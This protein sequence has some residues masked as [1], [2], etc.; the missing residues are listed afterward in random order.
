MIFSRYNK[1]ILTRDEK[2]WLEYESFEY[3][4]R[5]GPVTRQDGL[6]SKKGETRRDE[7]VSISSRLETSSRETV[8]KENFGLAKEKFIKSYFFCKKNI[9]EISHILFGRFLGLK[10]FA[11]H[12]KFNIF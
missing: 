6:V 10:I 4:Y 7:T 11:K 8:S 5:L 12:V 1:K 2:K 3:E 9:L